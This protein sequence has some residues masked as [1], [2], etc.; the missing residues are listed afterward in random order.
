MTDV[1]DRCVKESLGQSQDCGKLVLVKVKSNLR[2]NIYL[3]W[4][5]GQKFILQLPFT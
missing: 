1:Q 5:Y 2:I 4:F 3:Y